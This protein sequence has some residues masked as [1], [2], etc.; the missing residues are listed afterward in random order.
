[1]LV[2]SHPMLKC[3]NLPVLNLLNA[4]N[5]AAP[6]NTCRSPALAIREG[7]YSGRLVLEG[8]LSRA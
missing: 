2:H 4:V 8:R 6:L 1:M 3:C 5:S 7:G